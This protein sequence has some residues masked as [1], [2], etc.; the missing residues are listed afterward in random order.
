LQAVGAVP[1]GPAGL[2]DWAHLEARVPPVVSQAG[3]LH[4][5]PIKTHQ[6]SLPFHRLVA[7]VAAM[8]IRMD[9]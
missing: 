7:G 8:Q 1:A 9:G 2:V 3:H 5:R 4:Y 6:P